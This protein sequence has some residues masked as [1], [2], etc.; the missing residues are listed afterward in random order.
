MSYLITDFSTLQQDYIPLILLVFLTVFLALFSGPIDLKDEV[1]KT[2]SQIE[3][4]SDDE[5][6]PEEASELEIIGR[7]SYTNDNADPEPYT[8]YY[9][10][11]S[12]ADLV[13]QTFFW[14]PH[15]MPRIGVAVVMAFGIESCPTHKVVTEGDPSSISQK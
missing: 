4:F 13:G 9:C 8:I 1:E 3:I 2:A 12:S 6:D 14:A 11:R 5:L 10:R 7:V 15:R